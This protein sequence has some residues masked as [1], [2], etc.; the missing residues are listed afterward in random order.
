LFGFPVVIQKVQDAIHDISLPTA[1]V[2]EAKAETLSAEDFLGLRKE[3]MDKVRDLE[4]QLAALKV[5]GKK[6]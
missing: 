5:T 3:L 2:E 1:V 4:D 6:N